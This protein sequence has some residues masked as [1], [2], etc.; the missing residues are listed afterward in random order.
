MSPPPLGELRFAFTVLSTELKTRRRRMPVRWRRTI[1]G[2]A[3][4]VF[5]LVL[6]M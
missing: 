6:F 1:E 4:I 2:T 3:V 5:I